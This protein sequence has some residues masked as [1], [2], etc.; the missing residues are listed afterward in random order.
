MIAI[1]NIKKLNYYLN[2]LNIYIIYNVKKRGAEQ[3]L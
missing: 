3:L 2:Y 1:K